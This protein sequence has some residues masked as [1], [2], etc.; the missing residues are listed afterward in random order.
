V[1]ILGFDTATSATA[2]ALLDD[3]AGIQLERRDDPPRD[4]RPRHA[5]KLMPLIAELLEGGSTSWGD[6]DR[7][8]VGIGPGTFT[9]LRIGIATARALAQAREI[10]LVGV[11]TLE[12]LALGVQALDD[13]PR[14]VVA[15]IDARRSEAFAATWLPEDVG[16]PDASPLTE[17]RAF[18]AAALGQVIAGLG[19]HT[20]AVGEGAVKFREVLERSGA[21]IPEDDSDLHRVT[22]VN[23]CRL[24]RNR[25]VSAPDEIRPEYLRLPDAELS[26]H[27]RNR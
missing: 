3:E 5:T 10:P 9:G 20:L 14:V 22:A 2:V 24:A 26:R 11:S 25:L 16:A 8:A 18:T 4:V 7:I 6:I 17:P 27:A 12:S 13:R 1:R 21:S 15:V 19:P 23:H